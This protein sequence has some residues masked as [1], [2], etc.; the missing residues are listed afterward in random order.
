MYGDRKDRKGQEGN[1]VAESQEVREERKLLIKEVWW[2]R[3]KE[4][5][6]KG[7]KENMNEHERTK[8][9]MGR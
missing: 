5:W 3:R 6:H 4:G 7:T 2:K 9:R 1:M 8:M